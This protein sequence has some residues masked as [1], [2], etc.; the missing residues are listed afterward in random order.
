MGCWCSVQIIFKNLVPSWSNYERQGPWSIF[1]ALLF[2]S[3]LRVRYKDFSWFFYYTTHE[4]ECYCCFLQLMQDIFYSSKYFMKIQLLIFSQPFARKKI[5]LWYG[6]SH[7]WINCRKLVQQLW[8]FNLRLM[9]YIFF[10]QLIQ[11]LAYQCLI[12]YLFI[13]V[14]FML[15]C[16]WPLRWWFCSW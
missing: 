4:E 10:L 5:L 9:F 3:K 12:N 8:V 2:I 11:N 1:L 16:C 7:H 6:T 13:F 15:V 14:D